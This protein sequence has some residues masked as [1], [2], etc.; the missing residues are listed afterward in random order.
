MSGD[1]EQE[2]FADG[3][4]EDLIT[5]LSRMP[6]FYVTARNTSFTYKGGAVDIRAAGKAMGLPIFLKEVSAR[7]EIDCVSQPS[8]STQK[9]PIMCGL[10]A[11][12]GKL[13]MYLIFR[14]K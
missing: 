2:Y 8:L 9:L 7:A 13:S 1:P 5:E 3:M 10:I 12:I 11:T 6:W 4:S 14:M